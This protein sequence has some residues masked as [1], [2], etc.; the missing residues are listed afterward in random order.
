MTRR[1][2]IDMRSGDRREPGGDVVR[3]PVRI[4]G[5]RGKTPGSTADQAGRILALT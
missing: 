1:I 5:N 3:E 4:L 2:L